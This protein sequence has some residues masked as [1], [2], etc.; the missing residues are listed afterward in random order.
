[1]RAGARAACPPKSARGSP[2]KRSTNSTRPWNESAAP[3]SRC[4]TRRTW[5]RRRCRRSPAS[6]PPRSGR[7]P[8]V[9][10]FLMP[11]LGADMDEGTVLE[12]LVKPGA[13]VCKGD[14]IAVIDTAKSAIEV[15]S[16]HTGTVERLIVEPGETVPVGTVLALIAE[17]AAE[18]AAAAPAEQPP[19]P[20][21]PPKA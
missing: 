19:A 5:R 21:P 12:W 17:P 4:P 13:P 11:A 3:R 15:E 20:P 8:E 14:I 16:F 1:M 6:S 9:A 18:T 7:W 2:N 10:E